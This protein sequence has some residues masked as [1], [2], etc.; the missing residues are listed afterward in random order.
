MPQKGVTPPPLLRD[1]IFKSSLSFSRKH[2]RTLK[3]IVY[4][5]GNSITNSNQPGFISL[6]KI[7]KS[8]VRKLI[9]TSNVCNCRYLNDPKNKSNICSC[10]V[11]RQ[12]NTAVLKRLSKGT[13]NQVW[14]YFRTNTL[15]T[16]KSVFRLI[17][18]YEYDSVFHNFSKYV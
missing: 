15:I 17:R 16:Y 4:N 8:D 11:S 2:E 3:V 10:L 12:V 18:K 9:P 5:Q 7:Q 13:F 1:V 14:A 6:V